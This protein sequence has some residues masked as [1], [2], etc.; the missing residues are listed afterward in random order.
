V[1]IS[2]IAIT[3]AEW[4]VQ[5]IHLGLTRDK[6]R[7]SPGVD[8]HKPVSRQQE[9]IQND[10]YGYPSYWG[11][12]VGLWGMG[13]YPSALLNNNWKGTPPKP[14]ASADVHLRSATEVRGYH[15][16]G[17]DGSIG[18]VADFI[19]DESDWAL[20]YL[21][22]DTSNWWVGKKVV[23]APVWASKVN[24]AARTVEVQLTRAAIKGSPAWRGPGAANRE[25]E[26]LLY[27]YYGKPG[28]WAPHDNPEAALRTVPSALPPL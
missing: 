20:R 27:E 11:S 24:W 3:D 17:L 25:Y 12:G 6:V 16:E 8:Q 4:P 5:V 23:I 10:Y 26:Q 7:H 1:L 22:I 9:E 2:P 28:Y 19:V 18:H 14:S 21:V 15:I 13:P